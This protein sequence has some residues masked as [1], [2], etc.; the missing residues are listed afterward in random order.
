MFWIFLAISAHFFWALANIGDKYIVGHRVKNP[1]VYI[2]WFTMTG[3]SALLII[4]FIDFYIPSTNV[5]F[6]LIIAGVFYFFGGLPYIKAMQIEEPTRVNVWWSLIPIFSL[7]IGWIFLGETF[8][9]FQ[10]FAFVLLVTG[11]FTASIHAK[12]KK[13]VFSKAFWYMLLACLSF[14][15]Y[16]IIFRYSMRFIPFTLGFVWVHL[17][18]FI[19]SFSLFLWKKFRLDFKYEL[20]RVNV[21]LFTIIIIMSSLAHLGAFFNQWALSL[22]SVALVFAMEGFQV[23]FVFVIATLLSIFWPKIVKEELDRKNVLLKLAAL[24][25]MICGIL[26]LALL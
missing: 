8:T 16:A 12:N 18:M 25:L 1:Y 4:P 9:N 24:V 11:A 22:S 14:A 3:I 15:I 6:W 19:F 2:A 7:I 13:I 21:N 5:M 26:I 17:I 23:I 20:K 10:L